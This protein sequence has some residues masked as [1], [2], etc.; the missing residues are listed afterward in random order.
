MEAEVGTP[1]EYNPEEFLNK[2]NDLH[3]QEPENNEQ[4]YAPP[5]PPIYAQQPILHQ[6][7]PDIFANL[8][9][10][11]YIIIFVAFLLGFFMGKTMQPVILRPG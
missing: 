8:D 3:E 1:I 9:K 7:K 10:T 5:Q 6:E 2:D 11:G 4:Y